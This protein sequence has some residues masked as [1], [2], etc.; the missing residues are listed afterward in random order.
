MVRP[1]LSCTSVK[2]LL[3]SIMA[4][5]T[6]SLPSPMVTD[7]NLIPDGF[8]CTKKMPRQNDIYSTPPN[9][10]LIKVDLVHVFC[11]QIYS[12]GSSSSSKVRVGGFHARPGNEDPESA[13]TAYSN[14]TRSPPN[15]YG[16]AVYKYLYVYDYQRE[17]YLAK[18]TGTIS[19]M[20]PTVLS[21][22]EI[23][24]IITELVYLC[25]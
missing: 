4:S 19:S 1:I 20:W 8:S 12:S 21:M 5:T 2:L 15:K 22:E 7:T 18:N 14:L 9:S 24:A 10:N 23:T 17:M 25:R 16:Y 3:F 11:G 13:T 6:H